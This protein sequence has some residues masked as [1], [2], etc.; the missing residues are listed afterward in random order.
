MTDKIKLLSILGSVRCGSTLLDR[1]LGQFPDTI[2]IGESIFV[3]ELGF[4]QNQLCACGASFLECSFWSAVREKIKNEISLEDIK[5]LA[6]WGRQ[7]L[8]FRNPLDVGIT[9][10]RLKKLDIFYRAIY[11]VS[12]ASLIVDSSK[13]SRY[14]EILNTFPGTEL[15][16]VHLVRDSRAVAFSLLRNKLLLSD[17]RQEAYMNKF[18]TWR[19]A[20]HWNLQNISADILKMKNYVKCFSLLRYEKFVCEPAN[21]ADQIR[22]FT[23][24]NMNVPYDSFIENQEVILK[25]GHGISGNPMRFKTGKLK[26]VLDQEWQ[27]SMYRSDKVL[28]TILTFPLLLKYGYFG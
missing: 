26:I 25:P 20:I 17:V 2:S 24:M 14:A 21:I 12:G 3:W 7:L 15:S 18:P 28:V 8:S 19:S 16:A 6:K 11:D 22:I 10:L 13:S 23:G 27:A 5:D 4:L 1:L 9:N